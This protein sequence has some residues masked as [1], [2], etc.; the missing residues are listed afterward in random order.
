MEYI[1]DA[2]K[3]MVEHRLELLND[4]NSGVAVYAVYADYRPTLSNERP[5]YVMA[6]S[7]KEAKVRFNQKFSWLKIFKCEPLDYHKAVQAVLDVEHNIVI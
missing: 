5:Y 6:R 1:S 2:Y 7:N 4:M 3:R